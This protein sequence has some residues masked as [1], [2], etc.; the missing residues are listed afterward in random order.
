MV[1]DL[2]TPFKKATVGMW[3]KGYG[4][5]GLDIWSKKVIIFR[6]IEF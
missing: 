6:Q 3:V 1:N 2:K 4:I 5:M